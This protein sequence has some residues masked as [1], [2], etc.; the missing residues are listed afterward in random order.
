[1][2]FPI[3]SSRAALKRYSA[4]PE[5]EI[6]RRVELVGSVLA[7]HASFRAY[8]LNFARNST[9]R[10]NV[11]FSISAGRYHYFIFIQTSPSFERVHERQRRT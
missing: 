5:V 8:K 2:I 1:M 10:S 6:W 9:T 11:I 3:G 7:G 4:R